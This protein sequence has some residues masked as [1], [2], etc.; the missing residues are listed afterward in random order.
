MS[1]RGP[2]HTQGSASVFETLAIELTVTA[3]LGTVVYVL[4]IYPPG[5]PLVSCN[6]TD[7]AIHATQETECKA[8]TGDVEARFVPL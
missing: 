5:V 6:F 2:Q 3:G 4:R 1:R 7:C 8:F